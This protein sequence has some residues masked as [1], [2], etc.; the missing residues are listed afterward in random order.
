[1]TRGTERLRFAPTPLHGDED[2]ERLAA[3]LSRTWSEMDLELA[4]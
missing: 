4:A 3:A 1:M 2:I